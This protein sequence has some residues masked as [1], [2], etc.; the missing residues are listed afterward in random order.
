MDRSWSL[1]GVAITP[2]K[3]HFHLIHEHPLP[4]EGFPPFRSFI[5]SP[6][7]GSEDAGTVVELVAISGAITVFT[8]G[9]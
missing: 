5:A 7:A 6:S 1:L 2:L 9:D 8:A 3:L 4:Q